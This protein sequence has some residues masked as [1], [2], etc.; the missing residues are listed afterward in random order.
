M[1]WK[2]EEKCGWFI[3]KQYVLSARRDQS[4]GSVGL[5]CVWK[6]IGANLC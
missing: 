1:G 5:F 4:A 3:R 6:Q 2:P